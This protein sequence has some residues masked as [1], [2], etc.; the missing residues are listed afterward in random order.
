MIHV[1]KNDVKIKGDSI[2]IEAELALVIDT[3]AREVGQTPTE[4]VEAMIPAMEMTRAVIDI[5]KAKRENEKGS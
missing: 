3:L 4:F 2:E 1:V 5:I